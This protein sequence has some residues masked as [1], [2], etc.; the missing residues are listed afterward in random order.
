MNGSSDCSERIE[1]ETEKVLKEVGNE[2]KP[3]RF[4]CCLLYPK[5]ETTCWQPGAYRKP[6]LHLPTIH[7][8]ILRQRKCYI[9]D[10]H[11]LCRCAGDRR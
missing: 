4:R 1:T 7:D 3:R 6:H 9:I 8:T 11:G 10:F 5:A 2:V